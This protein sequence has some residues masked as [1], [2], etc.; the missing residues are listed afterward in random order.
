MSKLEIL[1]KTCEDNGL[2]L[3]YLAHK[4]FLTTE[5]CKSFHPTVDMLDDLYCALV[6][7]VICNIGKGRT[8]MYMEGIGP[9]PEERHTMERYEMLR[10]EITYMLGEHAYPYE[11]WLKKNPESDKWVE[12]IELANKDDEAF[13]D[14]PEKWLLELRKNCKPAKLW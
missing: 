6:G 1:K 7:G 14:N 3:S 2:P 9:T 5:L 11:K 12:L 8:P 10:N 4:S 13:K